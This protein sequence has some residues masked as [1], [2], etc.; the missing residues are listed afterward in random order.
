MYYHIT[1][2]QKALIVL[3][4]VQAILLYSVDLHSNFHLLQTKL[5]LTPILGVLLHSMEVS[6]LGALPPKIGAPTNWVLLV[7]IIKDGTFTKES[8]IVI[9]VLMSNNYLRQVWIN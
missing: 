2:Y 5:N 7:I 3:Q 1:H 6:E 4:V 8:F 9:T